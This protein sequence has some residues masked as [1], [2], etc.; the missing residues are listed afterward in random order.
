MDFIYLGS[1][2]SPSE[3]QKYIERNLRKFSKLNCA[4]RRN[5]GKHEERPSNCISQCNSKAGPPLW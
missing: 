2:I 1:H 4:L 5:F 3:H